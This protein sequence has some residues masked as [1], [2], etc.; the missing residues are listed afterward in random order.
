[1]VEEVGTS[2]PGPRSGTRQRYEGSVEDK[3]R[4][5]YVAITR[6]QKFLFLTWAPVPDPN[7]STRSHRL[8]RAPSEF[9]ESCLGFP[10]VRR[11][12]VDFTK[13]TRLSPQPRSGI[14][15]V[16]LTF[17]ELK[18]YFE[19]P[20]Q[21]KLRILYGFN[22]SIY[23]GLGYGRSLHNA[24]A[25]VHARVLNKESVGPE[26][27]PELVETHLH[28]PYAYP[29]L[30]EALT[31]AATRVLSKYLKDN[32]ADLKNVIYSEKQVEIHLPDGITV[33]GRIDLVRRLD[34]QEISIVDLKSSDRAQQEDVTEAQLHI[35]ALGI[36]GTHRA[37]R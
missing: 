28:L 21:F 12:P 26:I 4:L 5:F 30:K 37:K 31:K 2:S 19:C 1:M 18:Y 8:F 24:L 15:N 7:D 29:A 13:R 25:D 33:D 35:Y 10:S 27:V 34:T 14:E 17:S 36:P 11:R 20:Y 9:S 23:E 22:P 3:R 6:S 16:T 32:A